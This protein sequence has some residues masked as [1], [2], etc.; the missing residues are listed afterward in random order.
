MNLVEQTLDGTKFAL[1]YQDNGKYFVS[2]LDNVGNEIDH[3]D[4]SQVL[5]LN[6]GSKP[7]TGFNEPLITCAFIDNDDIFIQCY[8]RI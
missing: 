3:L 5:A 2:F 7:I 8:H 4:V 1:C 6:D